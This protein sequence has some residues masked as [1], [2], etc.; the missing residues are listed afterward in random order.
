MADPMKKFNDQ[1]KL[2]PGMLF[3]F[4]NFIY[5][6][7]VSILGRAS[8]Y[9]NVKTVNGVVMLMLGDN[10]K[11]NGVG[12]RVEFFNPLTGDKTMTDRV[13]ASAAFTLMMVNWF[14]N[15][16]A[17][18]FDDATNEA[19]ERVYYALRDIGTDKNSGVDA[20]QFCNIND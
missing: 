9:W 18:R 17:E 5:S 15:R 13:T 3:A 4:D 10:D 19:F 14:W 2:T 6:G 7:S 11:T 1:F 8:G 20:L 16:H 12:D